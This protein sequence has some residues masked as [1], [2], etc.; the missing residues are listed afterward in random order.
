M[1]AMNK[2][3][4]YDP[5]ITE[6]DVYDLPNYMK[7]FNRLLIMKKKQILFFEKIKDFYENAHIY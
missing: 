5:E 2:K 7:E 1:I 4:N 3:H 6:R